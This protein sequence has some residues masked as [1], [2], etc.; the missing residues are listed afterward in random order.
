MRKKLIA[1][2]TALTV[3]TCAAGIISACGGGEHSH[4]FSK[5]WS[6]DGTHHWHACTVAGCTEKESYAQHNFSENKCTV[7]QYEKKEIPVVKDTVTEDES[8]TVTTLIYNDTRVQLLSETLVRIEDKTGG[9]FEDRQSYIVVNKSDWGAKV[10]Y[11]LEKT[12]GGNVIKTTK[13]AVEIPTGGSAEDITVTDASGDTLYCY[14]GKTGT[15]L[16]LPSPSDELSSWYFTDSPRVIPSSYGYSP[17]ESGAPLQGW[18]FEEGATDI[19]VF[20][21]DGSYRSFSK[22]FITLTGQSEMVELKTFGQ[23][24]SRFYAYTEQTALQQ[25][26]DYREKGFAIDVLVVDT[27]WRDASAGWGYDINTS[28]FPDMERFLKEAHKL[29]ANVCFNDHPQPV[30]GNNLLDKEEVA[31]RN[32]KLTMLLA[33]GADNWWYDRNWSVELNKINPEYSRYATGMYAYQWITQSYLESI[34]DVNEYARR[35]VI[36]GNVDG[37]HNGS[38]V[39]ASD[40][41]AHRY[42]IQWSGDIGA[43]GNWLRQEIEGA[44]FA[45]AELGLPYVSADIGGHNVDPSNEEYARWFQYGALSPILRV[46]CWNDT[47]KD[48]RMPWNYGATAEE[49]A[50][51]YQ[52]MR[53]RLLPLYYALAHENYQTGLP[54]IRRLDINYPKYAEAKNNDEYLLGDY[55]LVAPIYSWTGNDSR[56]VFLPEGTWI[57]VWTGTRYSGPDTVTVK[58]GIKTSPVFVREGALVALARNMTN[59]DEKD[60][61]EMSLEIYPSANYAARTIVYEDDTKT[62]GYKD[63]KFRTTDIAMSC[64]GN[65]LKI[66]IGAAQGNFSGERAFTERVWNLRLHTN[67]NWGKVKSVKVNGKE[68]TTQTLAQ[69]NYNAGGRPFAFTGGALDGEVSAFTLQTETGKAYAIEIEYDSVVDSGKNIDYDATALK[70]TVAVSECAETSV[71]LTEL[72]TVDWVSYGYNSGSSIDYRKNGKTLF[73]SPVDKHLMLDSPTLQYRGSQIKTGLQKVYS[74][75][76]RKLSNTVSGGTRNAIGYDFTISTT[77]GKESIVLYLGG[78]NTLA[79]LT[80]RDRAGNVK[81]VLLGERDRADFIQKVVIEV[82]GGASTLSLDYAPVAC[83]ANDM[84]TNSYVIMYCGYIAGK[85]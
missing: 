55:I 77:G 72:G 57:D 12:S 61:S 78:N 16:Y 26:K 81:T 63:N 51:T 38:Y 59:V 35:A 60:W 14:T 65:T 29:G 53:Y 24:D 18:E 41:S 30:G 17:N 19:Y 40:L 22:D 8:K 43:K 48:G 4:S 80:V 20:V 21:P 83:K 13:F 9:A 25:I 69:V 62:V 50:H 44:V 33:M 42:S 27:D 15:N 32:E 1:T 2:L 7:C 47:V 46:H 75:G 54:I 10:E 74:D 82:D 36:M 76:N 23:W 79:K 71:N 11:S 45:G 39:Y 68:V 84:A 67:P 5:E 85:N 34:T 31:Y 3:I 64:V 37:N 73:S 66:E 70:F 6:A 56:E 28:L 52:D 49:V 58:H